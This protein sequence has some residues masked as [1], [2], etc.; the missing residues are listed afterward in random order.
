MWV[1]F[2]NSYWSAVALVN[3]ICIKG[4]FIYILVKADPL[5]QIIRTILRVQRK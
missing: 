2:L 5:R 4:L 1:T 3:K